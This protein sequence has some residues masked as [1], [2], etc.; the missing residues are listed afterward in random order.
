MTRKNGAPADGEENEFAPQ[1]AEDEFMLPPEGEDGT[2]E[3]GEADVSMPGDG[4][5][6]EQEKPEGESAQDS[7]SDKEEPEGNAGEGTEEPDG[8]EEEIDLD[9]LF[10]AGE[11]AQDALD[12]VN[13][14]VENI[15]TEGASKEEVEILK[16]QI[17]RLESANKR[18]NE[19]LDKISADK[20]ELVVKNAELTAFGGDFTDNNVLI[21]SRNLEKARNGDDKAKGK[22]VSVC[23]AVLEELTGEDYDLKKTE[24]AAD[25]L[26]QMESYNNKSK[27]DAPSK[28]E[29]EDDI[30]VMD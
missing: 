11:D 30:L 12:E 29:E 10:S 27:S 1:G 22:A 4:E 6:P 19:Q 15:G 5:E 25:A 8:D 17:G 14:T 2:E 26:S 20:S 18:L 16:E 7:E 24:D 21:L 9:E 13:K 23:K 28:K 3:D